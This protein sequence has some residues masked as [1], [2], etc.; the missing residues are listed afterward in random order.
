M[1]MRYMVSVVA[2]VTK[3]SRSSALRHKPVTCGPGTVSSFSVAPSG[4]STVIRPRP[5]DAD[6]TS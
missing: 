1:A 4:L 3:S 2:S 5:A 6:G